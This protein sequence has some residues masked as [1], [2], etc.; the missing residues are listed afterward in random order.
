MFTVA[1]V[2]STLRNGDLTLKM[3][4]LYTYFHIPIHP[5][6]Q[7]YQCFA[8]QS[9]VYICRFKVLLFSLN[10][11]PQLSTCL[12]H[13]RSRNLNQSQDIQFLGIRRHLDQGRTLL[14]DPKA[15]EIVDH[16]IR[17]LTRT[18]LLCHY[19]SWVHYKAYSRKVKE[20][21]SYFCITI[22][23]ELVKI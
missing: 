13:T 16:A 18:C 8:F 15:R 22:T 17:L 7:K 11:R 2:L 5:D 12:E 14:P 9:K 21:K 4:L 3:D 23:S 19:S 20:Y 10:M 6:G 1:S